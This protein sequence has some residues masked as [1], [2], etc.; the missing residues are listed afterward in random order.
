MIHGVELG[1]LGSRAATVGPEGPTL[2]GEVLA[3]S[4]AA[5][6]AA[7]PEPGPLVIAVPGTLDDHHRRAVRAEAEALG[8]TVLRIV[9]A[10]LAAAL[11]CE[12]PARAGRFAVFDLGED[13][14]DFRVLA[15][16][17]DG[18]VEVRGAVAEESV[19]GAAMD[20]AVADILLSELG[21]RAAPQ[22]LA[23]VALA[24]GD[25][26][27]AL[28]RHFSVTLDCVLPSGRRVQSRLN[29]HRFAHCVEPLLDRLAR[30]CH[31][32]LEEAVLRTDEIDEVIL[33]G[34]GARA[35]WVR[36]FVGELFQRVP[37]EAPLGAPALGAAALAARLWG[38]EPPALLDGLCMTL[39]LEA[40]DG[41]IEWLLRRGAP[42][43][44]S[45]ER[46]VEGP[47]ALTVY[48]GERNTAADCRPVGVYRLDAGAGARVTFRVDADGLIDVA[49]EA[50]DGRPLPVRCER[51]A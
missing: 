10:P 14:F 25:A 22:T 1:R 37:V 46:F 3:P 34:D 50:T 51:P 49:A 11:A 29:R 5:A 38:G 41:Y 13:A 20:R 33:V 24:A 47:V 28:A 16:D 44:A 15:V 27:I 19:G 45:A 17:P 40:D 8:H 35:P 26:R 39:G 2:L 43:P 31:D 36:A 12:L 7:A 23:A 18:V 30:L 21:L 42:F 32:A 6:L 4:L 9:S 48:Q